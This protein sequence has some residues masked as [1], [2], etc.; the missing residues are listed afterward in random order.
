MNGRELIRRAEAVGVTFTAT[1][2][3]DVVCE[4]RISPTMAEFIRDNT[5]AIFAALQSDH[6][7]VNLDGERRSRR[8]VS[9]RDRMCGRSPEGAA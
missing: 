6:R 1:D 7:V 8:P 9:L 2:S 5:P 4:G 3:G